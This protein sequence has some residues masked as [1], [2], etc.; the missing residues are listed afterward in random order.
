MDDKTETFPEVVRMRNSYLSTLCLVALLRLGV[1]AA[2]QKTDSTTA[3]ADMQMQRGGVVSALLTGPLGT[4]SPIGTV[5]VTGPTVRIEW[6]DDRSGATRP[7][8][9]HRGS[10]NRDEG[11]VGAPSSYTPIEVD[12]RGNGNSTAALDA[13]LVEGNSYFVAVHDAGPGATAGIVACGQLAA[14]SVGVG[15]MGGQ[16]TDGMAMGDSMTMDDMPGMSASRRSGRIA[17]TSMT[18]MDHSV[19]NMPGMQPTKSVT[20]KSVDHLRIGQTAQANLHGSDSMSSILMAIHM[21]MMTDPVIRERTVTDSVLRRMM[22]QMPAE[23]GGMLTGDSVGPERATDRPAIRT[24]RAPKQR[25]PRAPATSGSVSHEGMNMRG[26]TMPAKPPAT[27]AKPVTK[28]GQKPA[29]KAAQKPAS[30]P[31]KDSMS[32]MDHSKMP[33]MDHNE[34]PGMGKP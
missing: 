14:G 30:R 7:W 19:M 1:S 11:M 33:G 4:R 22:A 27:T 8:Y 16:K 34:K 25:S 9:V 17:D 5:A 20:P 10:C 12:A 28:P 24:R 2:A 18:A 29:A 23:Y 31:M 15:R 32:A 21:R 26:V 3:H 13:P 6:A